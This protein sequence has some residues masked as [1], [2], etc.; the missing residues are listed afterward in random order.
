VIACPSCGTE[1]PPNARFCLECGTRLDAAAPPQDERRVVSILFV[2][3]VGFTERSDQADPEDVR[4]SLVPFH[5]RV[6]EDLEAFGGTL[7]KFIGDAVM[8]VFGAP[9]AHEDDP[10]RAVRAAFRILDSIQE[11]RRDDPDIAVRIAVDTGEAVV[12]FGQGPQVG[13]AVAGDV[14]NTTSRMQALAPRDGL[15]VGETTH[16]LIDHAFDTAA[17]PPATVKGKTEPLLVWEVVGERAQAAGVAAPG[18]V[19]R[20]RELTGLHELLDRVRVSREAELVTLVGEPGIGKSRLLAEF[21]RGVGD[22]A[23]WVFGRCVPYGEAVTMSAVADTVRSVVGI[24]PSAESDAAVASLT[25]FVAGIEDDPDERRWLVS[26]LASVLGLTGRAEEADLT[27]PPREVAGAWARALRAGGEGPLVVEIDDLHWAEPALLETVAGL[28]DVMADRPLLVVCAARPEVLERGAAWPPQRPRVSTIDLPALSESEAASLLGSLISTAVLPADSRS[29]LLSRAGGNPL[30]ALE[31]ARMVGEHITEAPDPAMPETVQAVISARLD[32]IPREARSL[33]LDAAVMGTA[34]WPSALASLGDLGESEVRVGLQ[35]LVRRGL[36]QGSPTSSFE[37]QPEYGFTHALIGEVAYLRIPRGRRARRHCSAGTWIAQASG[38]RAEERAELLARHFS[39]AVELAEAAGDDE[40]ASVACDPAVRWLMTAGDRARRLD[41]AGA[42]AQYDRAAH[43]VTDDS[44]L[45][46]DTLARS[47]RMGRRSGRIDPGEVLA[48]YQES[49][50][51]QR[52]LG[53]PLRVGEALTRLGSQAGA[54]GDAVRSSE[55]LAEAIEVLEAEPPGIELARAYAFRAEEAMFAGHA[56]ESLGF[57]DRALELRDDAPED[58]EIAVMAL[59]IRGDARCSLG[60]EGGLE[61]LERALQRAQ[62]GDDAADIVTSGSYL[63]EWLWA[64]EGPAAGLEKCVAALEVADHRGVVDQGLWAKAGGVA[65]LID[66]GDWDRA[67]TWAEEIL[68]TGRDRLDPALFAASR[69]AVSRIASLRGRPEG[70]GDPGALLALARPVGELHVLAPALAQ[71]SRLLLDAGRGE[72]A[73]E[74][75]REFAAVTR[76]V[77]PEYRESQLAAVTRACIRVGDPV[78]AGE[79]IGESVGATRRNRL[80]VSSARAA[81]S[82]ADGD[83][84]SAAAGYAEAAEG[85][86]A[87]G[88]PL[89][90]AEALAGLARCDPEATDARDRAGELRR[91]LGMPPG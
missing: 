19:G 22:G 49:L 75:L 11:L 9:L 60:E 16:R 17:L 13:E 37:G 83:L 43:L 73:L 53:D 90:E 40:L 70:A 82:E 31:F 41:A 25:A 14:V 7:D 86:R 58:D 33:V 32:A 15:V 56:R 48:R 57:A 72:E 10:V 85:W 71:A 67:V 23:R 91:R 64:L 78:L 88:D 6:K 4:R 47:A 39:T 62:A 68:A 8:G 69:T 46:A 61:D 45:R 24:S 12:S 77:A 30:Y 50:A 63:G 26:R 51:I 1:N 35:D 76:G 36:V 79:M 66:L 65:M 18:F 74:L 34:F 38:E 55:L 5:S 52:R 3:L 80:N 29:S 42:F 84:R 81:V 2:D 59:H 27:I 89:E 28:L 87:Y 20:S 44:A 54:V 21:R